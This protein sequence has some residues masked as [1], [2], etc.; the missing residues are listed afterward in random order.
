MTERNERK[1]DGLKR[2]KEGRKNKKR[3]N[4]SDRDWKEEKNVLQYK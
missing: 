4:K 2:R 1:I 3:M